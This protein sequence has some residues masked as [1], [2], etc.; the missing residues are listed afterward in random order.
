[1]VVC[2]E[3]EHERTST[4]IC[5]RGESDDRDYFQVCFH[6]LRV[7]VLTS[8]YNV[9]LKDNA[10]LSEIGWPQELCRDKTVCLYSIVKWPSGHPSFF[11][12]SCAL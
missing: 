9:N 6:D 5:R 10:L 12:N 4:S 1:M 8:N 3:Y 11:A 7:L 2:S